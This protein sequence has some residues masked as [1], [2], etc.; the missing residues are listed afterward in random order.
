MPGSPVVRSDYLRFI[1]YCTVVGRTVLFNVW[2]IEP[3]KVMRDRR[4]T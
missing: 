4:T 2:L 3:V 1:F